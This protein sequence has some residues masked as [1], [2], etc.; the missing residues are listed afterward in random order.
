MSAYTYTR[1]EKKDTYPDPGQI[2]RYATDEHLEQLIQSGY[3][4]LTK[5]EEKLIEQNQKEYQYTLDVQ[6]EME[7]FSILMYQ[8]SRQREEYIEKLTT[9]LK[10]FSTDNVRQIVLQEILAIADYQQIS[11]LKSQGCFT[12]R[13]INGT[14]KTHDELIELQVLLI[15]MSENTAQSICELKHM[16]EVVKTDKVLSIIIDEII[17]NEQMNDKIGVKLQELCGKINE[18][19]RF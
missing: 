19:V 16:M 18:C 14:E 11:S 1:E 3:F 15:K 5:D 8:K 6:R 9:F 7:E 10:S 2:S 13:G 12:L 17:I 4:D